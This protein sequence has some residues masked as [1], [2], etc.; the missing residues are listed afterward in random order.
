MAEAVRAAE[1]QE[2]PTAAE[3]GVVGMRAAPLAAGGKAGAQL[4]VVRAVVAW[5]VV[6]WAV[7]A[8]V[9]AAWVAVAMAVGM[10]A[11]GLAEVAAAAQ[12]AP[13]A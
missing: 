7:A 3:E 6:A 8:S 5:A 4:V 2:A 10:R 11:V 13:E 1:A 12:E 9:A